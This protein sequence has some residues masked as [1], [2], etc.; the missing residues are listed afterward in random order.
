[1]APQGSER[2]SKETAR[3]G[4]DAENKSQNVRQSLPSRG[5][6]ARGTSTRPHGDFGD[7]VKMIKGKRPTLSGTLALVRPL[8]FEPGMVKLGCESAFDLS[9]IGSSEV[10]TYL[11]NLL[12]EF[13]GVKTLLEV[14]RVQAP[15]TGDLNVMPQTL[16]EAD[17]TVREQNRLE[18]IKQA[19]LRPAVKAIREELNAEVG[20]V[21]VLESESSN[22]GV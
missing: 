3:P 12:S 15:Q 18:K 22:Q 8:T 14:E 16:D 4:R 6:P 2:L 9:T 10:M 20:R 13:F 17:I 19:K 5:Q 11:A 1:M 7:F 21:R